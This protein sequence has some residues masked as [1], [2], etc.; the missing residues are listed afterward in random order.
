MLLRPGCLPFRFWRHPQHAHEETPAWAG[1]P[2]K[3]NDLMWFPNY[4]EVL[5]WIFLLST[6][7]ALDI[8]TVLGVWPGITERLTNHLTPPMYWFDVI[9][10][11]GLHFFS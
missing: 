2:P 1:H 8:P 7:S 9:L 5:Y 4:W 3:R 11:L 6:T 10:P